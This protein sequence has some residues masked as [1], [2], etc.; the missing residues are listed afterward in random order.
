MLQT[1]SLLSLCFP[2]P[3]SNQFFFFQISLAINGTP[4]TSSFIIFFSHFYQ[5][6]GPCPLFF[7]SSSTTS[8]T[9]T[10]PP[11]ARF[12]MTQNPWIVRFL[13][14]ITISLLTLLSQDIKNIY[15]LISCERKLLFVHNIVKS[16]HLY[17]V[18]HIQRQI[19]SI[20]I[21]HK[22]CSIYIQTGAKRDEYCPYILLSQK[23]FPK[24]WNLETFLCNIQIRQRKKYNSGSLGCPISDMVTSCMYL[25]MT[26]V[27]ILR[28]IM[29]GKESYVVN[30]KDVE[31]RTH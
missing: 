26:V 8:I 2:C 15:F 5:V 31:C 23:Y 12:H 6:F 18:E 14:F 9:P 16:L 1:L 10:I 7:L 21:L 19:L 13:Y 3:I 28:V 24:Y 27:D 30:R 4:I 17:E 29:A 22:C 20:F 11:A 25:E